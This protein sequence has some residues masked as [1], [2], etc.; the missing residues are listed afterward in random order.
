[1]IDSVNPDMTPTTDTSALGHCRPE[2]DTWS[3]SSHAMTLY[4]ARATYL[5]R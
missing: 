2:M 4:Q 3:A 5:R 1:M